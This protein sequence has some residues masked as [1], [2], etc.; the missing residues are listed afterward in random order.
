MCVCAASVCS[1]VSFFLSVVICGGRVCW[2]GGVT[3]A[4][5]VRVSFDEIQG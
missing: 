3:V 2:D 4:I 1:L 5:R